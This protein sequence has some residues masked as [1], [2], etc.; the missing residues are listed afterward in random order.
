MSSK[1]TWIHFTIFIVLLSWKTVWLPAYG[2]GDSQTI[3]SDEKP[4]LCQ[5]SSR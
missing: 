4:A 5:F 1:Y 3:P 2:R